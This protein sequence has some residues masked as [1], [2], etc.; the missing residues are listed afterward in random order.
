MDTSL[1]FFNSISTWKLLNTSI[2]GD[3]YDC[4]IVTTIPNNIEISFVYKKNKSVI[5]NEKLRD[6]TPFYS[7]SV[8]YIDM[9]RLLTRKVPDKQVKRAQ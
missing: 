4:V 6:S 7:V 9:V 2:G 3:Q 1:E 5:Y 8:K